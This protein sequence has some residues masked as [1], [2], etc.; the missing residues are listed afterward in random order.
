MIVACGLIRFKRSCKTLDFSFP[1]FPAQEKID[2][3]DFPIPGND[4]A[5]R[6]IDLYCNLIKE[7]IVSAKKAAPTPEQ[8]ITSDK[9]E[10]V[11]KSSKTIQEKDREK[12]DKKFSQKKEQ[13]L[14]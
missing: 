6:S 14:N 3:I 10:E 2:N 13:K 5:R 1:T 12:L 7:T 4:D 11:K 8:K 9:K